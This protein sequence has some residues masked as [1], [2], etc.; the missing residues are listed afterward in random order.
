[1]VRE[2]NPRSNKNKSLILLFFW[3]VCQN[4]WNIC[5]VMFVSPLPQGCS[6]A[7]MM[8]WLRTSTKATPWA[9]GMGWP[10]V[11]MVPKSF[12]PVGTSKIE[13]STAMRW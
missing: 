12:V 8:Y 13:P 11:F 10:G 9:F 1:M 3:L 4:S 7:L 2:K 6:W 5:F